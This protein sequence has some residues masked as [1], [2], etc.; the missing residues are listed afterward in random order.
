MKFM[1]ELN[2]YCLDKLFECIKTFNNFSHYRQDAD[3]TLAEVFDFYI[4]Y[5]GVADEDRLDKSLLK[6]VLKK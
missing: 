6:K 2:Q 1:M 5:K 4:R 3:S